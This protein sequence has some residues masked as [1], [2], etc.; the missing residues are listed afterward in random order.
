[1]E[2]QQVESG[3]GD[4]SGRAFDDDVIVNILAPA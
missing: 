1:M 4:L 3:W 2:M